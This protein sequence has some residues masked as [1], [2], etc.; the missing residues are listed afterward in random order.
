[1][2]DSLVSEDK[3]NAS[4]WVGATAKEIARAVRRGDT[5]AAQVVSEHLD[6]IA[7]RGDVVS[8]FRVLRTTAAL[9]EAD[10][11]DAQEDL[12]NLPLAGVPIAVKENTADRRCADLERFGG[13]A[14]GGGTG[15]S[16]GGPPAAWCRCGGGRHVPHAGDGH[17]AVHRRLG[18]GHPQPVADG[19]DRGRLERWVGRRGRRRS[20]A[21]R[22]RQRRARLGPHS[23]RRLRSGRHQARSWSGAVTARGHRL[24]RAGRARHPRDHGGRRDRRSRRAGRLG[25]AAA[26]RA[27]C[28]CGSRCR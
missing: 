20:G 10:A 1:M 2:A 5:S 14:I 25:T 15:R 17:L 12:K 23:G 13:R 21:D 27:V 6:H 22:A 28:R 7:A 26:G 11:V 3:K 18:S 24:V 4:L 8:A 16:R 9:A 19:P